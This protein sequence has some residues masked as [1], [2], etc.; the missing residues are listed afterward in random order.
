[1][2]Q[3]QTGERTEKPTP[4]KLKEAKNRGQVAKSMEVNSLFMLSGMLFL[5][6]LMTEKIVM[7]HLLLS[8]NLMAYDA[9]VLESPTGI[10]VLLEQLINDLIDV[11]WPIVIV[12]VFISIVGNLVQTGPIFT[13]F[14]LKPDLQ[15]M[16]PIEGFKKIF[17]KKM[18]YEFIKTSIKIVLFA[19]VAYISITGLIMVLLNLVDVSPDSYGL[20]LVSMA[21]EIAAKLLLVVMLA[22]LVDF[23]YTRWEFMQNM[24]MSTKDI[25]DENK[26]REGDPLIRAKRR[27]LQKEALEKS[28]A[29]SNVPDADVLITNP[30]H[31]AIALK[32]DREK[33]QAPKT[34]AKGSGEMAQKMKEMA[35]VHGVV[36]VENKPLARAMYNKVKID[37]MI[38]EDMYQPVAKIYAWLSSKAA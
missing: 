2:A 31:L 23:S 15:R 27:E 17:S 9:S 5:A 19:A 25:K 3:D 36:I 34:I 1:M 7:G 18:V 16:N 33:M 4:F 28:K 11:Y 8:K 32:F 26:R 10:L 37:H 13:F 12:I 30:T 14:P 20:I 35:R 21:R 29:V 38:T 22:A 6:Y 24:R